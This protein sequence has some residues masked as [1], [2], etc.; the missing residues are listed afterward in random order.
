MTFRGLQKVEY[1][2]VA[3]SHLSILPVGFKGEVHFVYLK[4]SRSLLQPEHSP[5]NT[6][7]FL[8]IY[9]LIY[10]R[11]GLGFARYFVLIL[12]SAK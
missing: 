12:L 10:I 6:Q 7:Q 11:G 1:H 5:H 4:I 9:G 2:D 8:I 3:N